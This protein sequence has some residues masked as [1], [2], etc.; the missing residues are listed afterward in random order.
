M[1][2]YCKA[3]R[4][5]GAVTIQASDQFNEHRDQNSGQY[6]SVPVLFVKREGNMFRRAFRN[7]L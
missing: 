4:H 6:G 2:G 3:I 1:L 5:C 7:D